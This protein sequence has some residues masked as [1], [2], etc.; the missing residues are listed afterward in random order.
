MSD[1][2]NERNDVANDAEVVGDMNDAEAVGDINDAEAV[3]DTND[4]E[5]VGHTNDA[6][7]VGDMN[8][9]VDGNTNMMILANGIMV[10]AINGKA[11][12][13]Y[14]PAKHIV[15]ISGIGDQPPVSLCVEGRILLGKS[16]HIDLLNIINDLGARVENLQRENDNLRTIVNEIYYSP[17]MPGYLKAES[18]FV[19]LASSQEAI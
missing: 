8:D 16:G 18:S 5:A 10:E 7:A 6:E 13:V 2:Q 15:E 17:H 3:G 11:L 14:N 12:I 1:I 4:A 9:H 19:E